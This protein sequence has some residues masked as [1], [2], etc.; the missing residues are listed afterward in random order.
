MSCGAL[1]QHAF[2]DSLVSRN[3]S[4]LISREQFICSTRVTRSDATPLLEGGYRF[5]VHGV[6]YLGFVFLTCR[7]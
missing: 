5:V 6:G 2:S 3:T 1:H 7:R 4:L